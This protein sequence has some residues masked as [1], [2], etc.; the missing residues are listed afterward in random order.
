MSALG[1]ARSVLGLLSSSRENSAPSPGRSGSDGDFSASLALQMASLRS[2][3]LDALTGQSSGIGG[4]SAVSGLSGISGA[5]TGLS[6]LGRN[7]ALFDPES[8]YR[9]MTEINRRDTD[10]KAQYAELSDMEKAVASLQQ[11]GQRLAGLAGGDAAALKGELQSF[12]SAYNDWVSRFD[13]KVRSGGT[14]AGTQAA[15]VSLNELRFS[16]EDR[17]NGAAY[18][19]HGLDDL[20]VS[21][22]PLTH[23]AT[24]DAA[25]FDAAV[26]GNR[27]GVLAT[28]RDFGGNFAKSAGMLVSDNNFLHNRLANLDR[29]IGYIDSNRTSLQAEFGL[30]DPAKPS[31]QVQRALD[32]YQRMVCA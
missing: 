11:A 10:Y 15:E 6:P 25:R 7:L 31:A 2:S 32:A 4:L 1:I 12:T 30:G 21:I 16:I 27:D 5:S 29:A 26:A 13:I 9:M 28:L 14:L 22:D 3:A 24:F 19:M 18:G 8:G 17:F 23:V 20:G